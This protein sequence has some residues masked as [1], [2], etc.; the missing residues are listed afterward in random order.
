MEGLIRQGLSDEKGLYD[1]VFLLGLPETH[2]VTTGNY[3]TGS[4]SQE[5]DAH[6][7]EWCWPPGA[8]AASWP[9]TTGSGRAPT[10]TAIITRWPP[11]A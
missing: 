8:W 7:L 5:N 2:F 4:Q 11:P 6:L 9:R 10:S 1:A 3:S